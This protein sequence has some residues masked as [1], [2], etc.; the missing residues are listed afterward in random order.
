MEIDRNEETGELTYKIFDV[1]NRVYDNSYQCYGPIPK[2]ELLK[3]KNLMQ[4]S[5]WQ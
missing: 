5:G 3:F 2:S 4:N 1:E